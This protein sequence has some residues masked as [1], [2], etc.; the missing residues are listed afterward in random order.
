[1]V[2]LP[3]GWKN[4]L[5][6]PNV[7]QKLLHRFIMIK[8]V[9]AFFAPRTH[10]IDGFF[11]KLTKNKHTLSEVL[12]WNIIQLATI[13]A[14]TGSPYSIILIGIMDGERIALIA[15]NFG[16]TNNPAWY[17]NL[18]KNPACEVTLN[19]ISSSYVARETEGEERETYWSM[20]VS[21][22]AGY[23]K[24]KQ[25]ASHRRIP[26]LLLEPKK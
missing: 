21:H 8:Q 25:R 26:V 7:L 19:G 24:Y 17:Y 6:K 15:S 11:L 13:G 3:S 12:G 20:A 16:R 2:P 4:K 23:E 9:T 5:K 1:M 14:K 18:K 22:Y 10:L